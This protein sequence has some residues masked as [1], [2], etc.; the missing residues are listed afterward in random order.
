MLNGKE[1]SGNFSRTNNYQG[2]PKTTLPLTSRISTANS[3]TDY[4]DPKVSLITLIKNKLSTDYIRVVTYNL[5]AL[6]GVNPC[7][8]Q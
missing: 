5:M 2:M 8:I 1:L 3:Y 6:I 4:N 7:L